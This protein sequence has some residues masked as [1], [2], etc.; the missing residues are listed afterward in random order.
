MPTLTELYGLEDQRIAG[1]DAGPEGAGFW[2]TAGDLALKGAQGVVDIGQAA[3]GLGSLATG[4][5]VGKGMRAIGYDPEATNAAIGE[6][7]SPAQKEADAAVAR[8]SGFVDSLIA[9][10]RNPRAI[11]GQIAESLPGLFAMGGIQAAVAKQIALKAAAPLGGLAT[12]AGAAAAKAA[13]ENAAGRLMWVGGAAEGG[14]Q[15][16]Q[17]ADQAQQAG[18]EYSDYA[19]PAITSGAIDAA[20]ARASGGLMGSA[21]TALFTGSK[22]AGVKGSLPVRVAKSIFS[23]GVLEEMPQSAQEQI[24]Q[25]VAMGKPWDEGVSEQAAMGLVTGGAMG[26]VMGAF[27]GRAGHGAGQAPQDKRQPAA[28]E[29]T[30]PQQP[31]GG[32]GLAPAIGAGLPGIAAARS[33]DEAITAAAAAIS[34]PGSQQQP[35]AQAQAAAAPGDELAA[36]IEAAKSQLQAPG[37]MDA[38]RARYGDDGAT[39]M[40]ASLNQAENPRVA[41]EVRARH[42]Q[43][44]DEMLFWL[45]AERQQVPQAPLALGGPQE[46]PAL[47][48]S[49]AAPR[50]GF[51]ST[52]TGTLRASGR[53]IVWPET[54]ADAAA[55]Q[56]AVDWRTSIGRQA[57][58]PSGYGTA[59]APQQPSSGAFDAGQVSEQAGVPGERQDGNRSGPTAEAGGGNRL[60]DATRGAA[61]SQQQQQQQV[62]GGQGQAL[63]QPGPVAGAAAP[64]VDLGR[65]AGPAGEVA[66]PGDRG[67]ALGVGGDRTA[68]TAQAGAVGDATGASATSG[69]APVAVAG[70]G[71]P[72]AAL[73]PQRRPPKSFR[74]RVTVT[75]PVFDEDAGRFESTQVDADS[76]LAALDEDIAELRDFL[77]CLRGQ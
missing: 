33:V 31:P 15:A 12:D 46:L 29:G 36:G 2:R 14:Q 9:L 7:L 28:E 74:S 64:A 45:D 71:E 66:P 54:A 63:V 49:Q 34:V 22:A 55:T 67:S 39:E 24:A 8:A 44:V 6:Y 32:G 37:T 72:N 5:L 56:A 60:L 62:V 68:G 61:A 25:N 43:V 27:Q 20:I 38:I 21:E 70:S 1:P 42:L 16:G 35:A 53:G 47:G 51:G 73:T 65:V 75:T 76:A 41:P 69:L 19:L 4:G 48:M 17:L 13:V 18:R 10:A 58:S 52:P 23:E 11:G 30:A 26:G 57:P 50:I 59:A 3:V 40:L 77:L